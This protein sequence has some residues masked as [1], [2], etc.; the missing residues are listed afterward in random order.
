MADNLSVKVAVR[1]RPLVDHEISKG[2]KDILDVITENDQIIVRSIEKDKAFSFNYV[3]PAQA[4]Q[5]ELYS[6]C[7]QPLIANIFKVS[8]F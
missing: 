6:R 2:C 7:V 8:C 5:N 4:P 1:V 3:L